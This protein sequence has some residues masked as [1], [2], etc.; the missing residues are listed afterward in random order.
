MLDSNLTTLLSALLG[1]FLSIIGGVAANFYI[2]HASTSTEAK[3]EVK[4][5]AENIYRGTQKV[6]KNCEELDGGESSGYNVKTAYEEL[7]K[8][9]DDIEMLIDLYFYTA[10]KHFEEYQ[11]SIFDGIAISI[12]PDKNSP[13]Y[14]VSDF[15]DIGKQEDATRKFR[16]E[17]RS[18]VLKN[19]PTIPS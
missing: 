5:V 15:P 10:K 17:V 9:M 19:G 13:E 6:L 14:S 12:K 16:N 18:I 1:G 11:H 3:K 4:S 8:N 7:V 2:Q